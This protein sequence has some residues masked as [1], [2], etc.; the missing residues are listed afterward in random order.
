MWLLVAFLVVV[1]SCLGSKH[2]HLLTASSSFPSP[3]FGCSLQQYIYSCDYMLMDTSQQSSLKVLLCFLFCFFTSKLRQKKV[4]FKKGGGGALESA[5]FTDL[6]NTTKWLFRKNC[7]QISSK[8]D[9]QIS[10]SKNV[11]GRRRGSQRAV[12]GQFLRV[13]VVQN[14]TLLWKLLDH[15][16]HSEVSPP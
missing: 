1:P 8:E 7:L 4:K 2:R 9:W 10:E 3:M 14:C 12:I 16:A 13:D 6:L 5:V 11:T 15:S